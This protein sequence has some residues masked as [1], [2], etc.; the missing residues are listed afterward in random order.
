MPPIPVV[1]PTIVRVTFHHNLGNGRHADIVNDISVDEGTGSDRNTVVPLVAAAAGRQWQLSVCTDFSNA[2]TYTG[3]SF[4]DLDS[5]SSIGG[6]F[7]PSPGAPV[8]SGAASAVCPPN[9]AMLITKHCSHTRSQRDGRMFIPGVI[10]N[11][12][13]DTGDISTAHSGGTLSNV[14]DWFEAVNDVLA[15]GATTALRV[16]HVEGHTGVPEPGLPNG[17]PNAWS[18]SD[19]TTLSVATRVVTQRRRNRP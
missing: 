11:A 14:Q 17:R 4:M 5:L 8:N 7:G 18:S 9:V 15:P 2:I 19:V 13:S 1:A 12:V 16:V 10:E 3:G 6:T